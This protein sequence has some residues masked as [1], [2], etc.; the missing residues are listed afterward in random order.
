MTPAV[1]SS[2]LHVDVLR[3]LALWAAL[4]GG[5][6]AADAAW[7]L[8]DQAP[9]GRGDVALRDVARTESLD[10]T[11]AERPG[12]V[13]LGAAPAIGERL[14]LGRE[15]LD[16]HLMR[17]RFGNG[18]TSRRAGAPAAALERAT[19]PVPASMLQDAAVR[20]LDA[21]LAEH[22]AA[23]RGLQVLSA[24]AVTDVP[25][26]ELD[27]AA[28]AIERGRVPAGLVTVR[29]DLRVDG[30]LV[31][32]VPVALR[33]RAVVDGW[34]ARR[35]LA[36]H[37]PIGHDDFEPR[38]IDL[39]QAAPPWLGALPVGRRLSRP[40]AA[41]AALAAADAVSAHDVERGE[42][43]TASVRRGPIL[44]QA[45]AE[46]LQDGRVGQAVQVRIAGSTSAVLGHVVGRH[47]V[48]L[49][50]SGLPEALVAERALRRAAP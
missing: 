44:V 17:H 16:A 31:Q 26:G 34:A 11:L 1:M 48:M 38:E 39:G 46:T 41:G 22:G 27:V 23:R 21:A 7:A 2:E 19:Q 18:A 9:V 28:R 15:R 4:A 36:E 6:R 25:A 32:V 3:T 24:P 8:Q 50:E 49:E 13:A 47:A 40:L 5:C 37:A 12:R 29:I 43:V 30:R 10:A 20:A 45:R 42:A 35:S 14:N 33:V